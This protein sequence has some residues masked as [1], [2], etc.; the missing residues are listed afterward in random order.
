MKPTKLYK[1]TIIVW[2]SND[3]SDFPYKELGARIDNGSAYLESMTT[4]HVTNS[5]SYPSTDRFD[6]PDPEPFPKPWKVGF[7]PD[8]GAKV[9]AKNGITVDWAI[10]EKELNA[11]YK[12]YTGVPKEWL[13]RE[14][15]REYLYDY[16]KW[17]TGYK[18]SRIK[19][20]YG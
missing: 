11:L 1:R 19:G 13:E 10:V 18:K 15:S 17:P 7:H 4:E 2:T 6:L 5:A 3:P 9:Y 16:P 8:E 12:D 14:V 20:P